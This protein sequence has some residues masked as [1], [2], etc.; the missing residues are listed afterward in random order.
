VQELD[1]Y[2]MDKMETA[3]L[4]PGFHREAQFSYETDFVL[5]EDQK[6]KA[7]AAF[8]SLGFLFFFL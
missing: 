1:K 2:I 6:K 5:W 4:A 8:L 3:E 7:D